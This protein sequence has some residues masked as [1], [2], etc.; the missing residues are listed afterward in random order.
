MPAKQRVFVETSI[1]IARVLA[2]PRQR[3]RIERQLQQT[4]Y[5]FVL[6]L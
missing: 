1:Q 5:E 2:E 6:Y 3:G 4:E